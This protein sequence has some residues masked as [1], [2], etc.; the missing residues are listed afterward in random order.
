MLTS[1]HGSQRP[2]ARPWS[3]EQ[4]GLAQP[5]LRRSKRR[6]HNRCSSLRHHSS[7]NR[8]RSSFRNRS[9]SSHNRSSSSRR[10]DNHRSY[11]KNRGSRT[12]RGGNHRS[13]HSN[14]GC[15]RKNHSWHHR[16]C[17]SYDHR[18]NH[19]FHR[20]RRSRC[21]G[22]PTRPRSKQSDR[23]SFPQSPFAYADACE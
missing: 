7:S 3:T 12:C 11:R 15:R 22:R 19:S 13:C 4:P 21:R 9:S 14:H 8:S 20:R 23:N 16:S 1:S 18:T 10:F 6:S 5:W 17:R 2:S